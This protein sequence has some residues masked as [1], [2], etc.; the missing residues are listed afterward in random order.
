MAKETK[1][2]NRIVAND[3]EEVAVTQIKRNVELNGLEAG[4]GKTRSVKKFN[5]LTR[6]KMWKYLLVMQ[7]I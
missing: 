4:K 6:D 2:L 3:L 1:G 5:T 7:W